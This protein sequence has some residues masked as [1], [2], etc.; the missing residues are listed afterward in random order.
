[1]TTSL[2]AVNH[3]GVVVTAIDRL[4]SRFVPHYAAAG[5]LSVTYHE[6]DVLADGFVEKVAEMV[7]AVG[8]PA[9]VMGSVVCDALRNFVG[10]FLVYYVVR[11]SCYL[12]VC[13]S[14]LLGTSS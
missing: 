1:M 6:M 4:A 5:K 10:A 3:P 13:V 9:V 12:R 2:L 7:E 11:A 8:R 14:S